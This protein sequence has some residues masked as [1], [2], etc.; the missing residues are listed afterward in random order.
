[1]HYSNAFSLSHVENLLCLTITENSS[2]RII[3]LDETGQ[4]FLREKYGH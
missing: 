4:I 3:N 1:M 2:L